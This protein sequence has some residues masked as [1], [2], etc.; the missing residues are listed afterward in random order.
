MALDEFLADGEAHASARILIAGVRPLKPD[1]DPLQ[2]PRLVADA[3]VTHANRLRSIADRRSPPDG[4]ASSSAASRLSSVGLARRSMKWSD[5]GE[6][7]GGSNVADP[8]STSSALEGRFHPGRGGPGLPHAGYAA[9]RFGNALPTGHSRVGARRAAA[10]AH[11]TGLTASHPAPVHRGATPP[12]AAVSRPGSLAPGFRRGR[13]R[14]PRHQPPQR[15]H[16][17]GGRR[18]ASPP[19]GPHGP[20]P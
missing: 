8:R 5:V 6:S 12:L 16:P 1:E 14:P 13:H 18:Q 11:P 3:V 4:S 10:I 19:Y 17:S 2:T 15:R 20:R 7:V 9:Q